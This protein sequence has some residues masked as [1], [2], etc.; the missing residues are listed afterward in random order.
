MLETSLFQWALNF[1][2]P[3][4]QELLPAA[5]SIA[6]TRPIRPQSSISGN[7]HSLS[8]TLVPWSSVASRRTP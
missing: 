7:T 8:M 5:E 2:K 1:A 4:A 3:P 6:G